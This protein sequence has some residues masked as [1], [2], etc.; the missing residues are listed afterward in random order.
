LQKSDHLLVTPEN[1]AEF[2]IINQSKERVED[3][4]MDIKL[5]PVFRERPKDQIS[6]S[7]GSSER[8]RM[9]RVENPVE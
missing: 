3:S 2:F 1:R 7:L 6:S 8:E 4:S 9:G 5:S